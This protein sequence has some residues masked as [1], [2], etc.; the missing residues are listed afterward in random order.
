MIDEE[1]NALF[2][3]MEI[4]QSEIVINRTFFNFLP[5][6]NTSV[7]IITSLVVEVTR[8]GR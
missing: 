2:L 5:F 7:F 4:M 8:D 3:W 6:L 1:R